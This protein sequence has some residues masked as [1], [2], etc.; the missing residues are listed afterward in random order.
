ME[1]FRFIINGKE[2]TEEEWNAEMAKDNSV[3]Y[4][5]NEPNGKILE[6]PTKDFTKAHRSSTHITDFLKKDDYVEKDRTENLKRVSFKTVCMNIYVPVY[7]DDNKT[8]KDSDINAIYRA[9]EKGEYRKIWE[10]KLKDKNNLDA[11]DYSTNNGNHIYTYETL[12][13]FNLTSN[14]V[15]N[16]NIKNLH[17]HYKGK[18]YVFDLEKALTLLCKELEK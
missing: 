18:E 14:I 2:V 17:I 1:H 10:R 15:L 9:D 8:I 13:N 6:M 7:A 4:Y 3:T 16:E 5:M 11:S 12:H